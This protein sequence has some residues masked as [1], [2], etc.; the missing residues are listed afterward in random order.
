MHRTRFRVDALLLVLLGSSS[1]LII[2]LRLAS[3]D[4]PPGELSINV[5]SKESCC[6]SPRRARLSVVSVLRRLFQAVGGVEGEFF[7]E[8]VDIFNVLLRGVE[9]G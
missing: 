6:E 4:V 5:S 3:I 7:A 9:H 8:L 2:V 1:R